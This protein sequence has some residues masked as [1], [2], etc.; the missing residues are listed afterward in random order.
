MI[1]TKTSQ[2]IVVDTNLASHILQEIQAIESRLIIENI[3]VE[4]GR[5]SCGNNCRSYE[6][7]PAITIISNNVLDSESRAILTN[8]TGGDRD[9][10]QSHN[11]TTEVRNIFF[12]GEMF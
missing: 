5:S 10:D 6:K 12:H 3:G 7:S 8:T 4:V 11:Q 2:T 1:D 9:R